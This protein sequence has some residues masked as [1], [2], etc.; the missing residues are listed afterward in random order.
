[1]QT[2]TG[3]TVRR[4]TKETVKIVKTKECFSVVANVARRLID[5]KRAQM[6][7]W[8][9]VTVQRQYVEETGGQ[10][11]QMLDKTTIGR[12]KMHSILVVW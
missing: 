12:K 4:Q 8:I 1:M 10:Q 3:K 2:E 9:E 11:S 5:L 7:K 6:N